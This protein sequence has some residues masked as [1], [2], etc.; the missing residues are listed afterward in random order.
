MM[1]NAGT[2]AGFEILRKPEVQARLGEL[3]INVETLNF[4][5]SVNLTIPDVQVGNVA[6]SA[7]PK[8]LRIAEAISRLAELRSQG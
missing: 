2:P 8:M 3:Q 7:G 4:K 5:L 6:E 1:V